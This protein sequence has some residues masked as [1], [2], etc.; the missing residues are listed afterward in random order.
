M[1]T[2]LFSLENKIA[3]VTGAGSGLGREFA[4]GLAAAG[5]YVI[6]ADRDEGWVTE[7]VSLIQS[8][9][10]TASHLVFDVT[11]ENEI[12]LMARSVSD[13]HGKLHVLVNNAGVAPF[14][15]RL[16][17]VDTA[18]WKRVLDTNLTGPFLVTRALIP[19]M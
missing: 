7:T 1:S 12:A 9:D 8:T 10:G 11:S 4:L 2:E 18:D 5:A 6:C 19:L 15:N 13:S 3:L 14:P 16:H 17:E